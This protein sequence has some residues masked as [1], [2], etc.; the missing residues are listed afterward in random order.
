MLRNLL[1]KKVIGH[2]H[3][4]EPLWELGY[5]RRVNFYHHWDRCRNQ[6]MLRICQS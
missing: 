4:D 2:V 1:R 3:E 5:H 6:R